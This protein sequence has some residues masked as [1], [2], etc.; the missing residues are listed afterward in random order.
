MYDQKPIIFA[1]HQKL[2][3][4]SPRQARQL[5]VI[6]QYTT[7]IRHVRGSENVTADFLSRLSSISSTDALDYKQLAADQKK[8]QEIKNILN[9]KVSIILKLFTI[10]E[11]DDQIYCDISDNNIRPYI[12]TKFRHTVLHKIHGL[13]HTGIRSTQKLLIKRFI[14]IDM[15]KDCIKYIRS[16]LQ[17]QRCKVTRHTVTPFKNYKSPTERFQHISIDLIGPMPPSQENIYCLT[18]IDRFTHWPEA[19]PLSNITAE[20]TAKNLISGWISKFGVPLRIT[21]D[22]GQQFESTLFAELTKLLG[23]HHLRTTSYHLQANGLIE[24][25][26]RTLNAA[27]GHF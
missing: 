4:A 6:G 14:W 23:I 13:A 2:D 24:R 19:I 20:T 21:T 26:N 8:D 9:G 17:C 25:W 27:K 16:C 11:V 10:P 7:A 15:R 5:D 1:F 12:T 18:I 22:Q 3:K